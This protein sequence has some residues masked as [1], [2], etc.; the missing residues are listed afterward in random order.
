MKNKIYSY[1]RN[2]N[3]MK[4]MALYFEEKINRFKSA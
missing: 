2:G 4:K 3:F 1:E